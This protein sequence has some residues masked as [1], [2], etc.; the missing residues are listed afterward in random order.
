M[1]NIEKPRLDIF[2]NYGPKAR[3]WAH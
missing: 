2:I 1:T 3:K